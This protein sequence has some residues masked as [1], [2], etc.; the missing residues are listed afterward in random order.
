LTC[1]ECY[2]S[3]R[4]VGCSRKKSA[5]KSV[6]TNFVLT[7][8]LCTQW[9]AVAAL[10]CSGCARLRQQDAS[11]SM[12]NL[13]SELTHP[14]PLFEAQANS[15]AVID[16]R[17]SDASSLLPGAVSYPVVPVSYSEDSNGPLDSDYLIPLLVEMTDQSHEYPSLGRSILADHVN[18]YSWQSM[19]GL[20]VGLGMG[21]VLANSD[22]DAKINASFQKN[23]R[24]AESD[25]AFEFLRANKELGNGIYT[26]PIFATAWASGNLFDES[27]TALFAGEWGER[28]LRSFLVGAPPAMVMQQVTGG[29]RPGE[30]GRDSLWSPFQDNNG[31]SG[32]SFMGALPFI[33]AAKMTENPWAKAT[34]YAGST[35]APLSR[36][37]DAA[38]YPSQSALGW[39]MA[40][41]AATAVDR[42]EAA[43]SRWHFNPGLPTGESG[44]TA[45]YS[46]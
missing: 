5:L 46:Y 21:A 24:R 4:N 16:D 3:C 35:L 1:S 38:H 33:N 36:V 15:S 14:T 22:A 12:G 26:L 32:H 34:L 8:S 25:D 42:T 31:V 41:L 23:F 9:F 28:S 7:L 17:N 30:T 37:N 29:S 13:A 39:W 19:S 43:D 18:Y 20:A 27:E 6:G 40:Y 10:L 44:V 11:P 2:F 45:E